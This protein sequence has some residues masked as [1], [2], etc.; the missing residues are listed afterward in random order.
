LTPPLPPEQDGA[1]GL[2]T[3][4]SAD[5]LRAV[6]IKGRGVMTTGQLVGRKPEGAPC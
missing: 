6:Q 3:R 1:D 5:V 4:V 2:R